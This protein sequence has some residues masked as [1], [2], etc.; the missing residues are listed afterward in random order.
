MATDCYETLRLRGINIPNMEHHKNSY[1]KFYK[2]LQ[3][4]NYDKFEDNARLTASF[5][6]KPLV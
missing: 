5:M 4:N 2:K 1:E 3:I 6:T